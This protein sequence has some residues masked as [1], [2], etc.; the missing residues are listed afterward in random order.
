[1]LKIIAVNLNIEQM[2]SKNAYFL[3]KKDQ[4]PI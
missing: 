3:L 4:V 1:M 2:I